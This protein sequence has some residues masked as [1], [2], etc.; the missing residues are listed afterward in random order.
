MVIL[1]H[2]VFIAALMVAVYFWKT[3][4]SN[5]F[6]MCTKTTEGLRTILLLVSVHCVT[7]VES[8]SLLVI[9]LLF[10]GAAQRNVLWNCAYRA[11]VGFS[12]SSCVA[13][14]TIMLVSQSVHHFG[15]NVHISVFFKIITDSLLVCWCSFKHR[16]AHCFLNFH[17]RH[18]SV[19]RLILAH[20]QQMHNFTFF[21]FIA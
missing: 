8:A 21:C 15:L 19:S 10:S 4:L 12:C 3:W 20:W 9:Q 18:L 13:S 7:E 6:S 2:R 11:V 14:R 16:F 1:L 17:K 5:S